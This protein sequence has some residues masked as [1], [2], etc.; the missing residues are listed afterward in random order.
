MEVQRHE[1]GQWAQPSALV[2]ML[3]NRRAA[4]GMGTGL[5]C[6]SP[7]SEET[8]HPLRGDAQLQLARK[9]WDTRPG[10]AGSGKHARQTAR[11]GPKA[12]TEGICVSRRRFWAQLAK[13]TAW[14]AGRPR[15]Q[16][17]VSAMLRIQNS[18]SENI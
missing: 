9:P 10:C 18:P 1:R 6:T 14:E 7:S 15:P 4:V 17:H 12:H 16:V 11:E 2:W 3:C 5:R 8:Q 13:T